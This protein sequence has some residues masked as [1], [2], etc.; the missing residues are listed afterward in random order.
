MG[1]FVRVKNSKYRVV[2]SDALPY[3]HPAFFTNRFFARF[4]KY[5]GV[6]VK[7]GQ[8]EATRNKDEEGL[9]EFLSILGGKRGDI[10]LCYQYTIS[11]PG[12]DEGRRL[13]VIHPYHQV[14]LVEFYDRY[15]KL[16]IEFCK[17]S[18]FSIRYP[19]K[20]ASYQK[21]A[22][23][24]HKFISDDVQEW[25]SNDRLRHFFV[26]R[27]Y[28]NI[29]HFYGD[30][31]FLRA[32]KQFS[33][34][35]KLDLT[36]CF[37]RIVPEDLSEA[38]FE[39]PMENATGS[40]AHCFCLLQK[41][42]H[43][44]L[45]GEVTGI[46]IGPEFSRIYAEMILQAVDVRT[47]RRLE[48]EFNLHHTRD[49][50]FYRYVDDGFL[51]Y[52]EDRVNIIF[53]CVYSE[54]L[55]RFNQQIN[56]KKVS[57]FKQ[58]PFVE[59]LAVAKEELLNLVNEMF[60]NR[61]KTF[62]G[63]M[64]S[65]QGRYDSPIHTDYKIFINRVRAIIA[66][67]K[68]SKDVVTY[69]KL[70]LFLLGLIRVRLERLLGDFNVLYR[71]YQYVDYK[72]DIDEKGLRIKDYYEASFIDFAREL[73]EILFFLLNSD[74]RMSTSLKV[75]AIINLLQMFVRG[76]YWFEEEEAFSA[77]FPI[78]KIKFLDGKISDETSNYIKN[79][80]SLSAGVMETLNVLELQKVMSMGERISPNV[81]HSYLSNIGKLKRNEESLDFFSAFELL[82]LIQG[83]AVYSDVSDLVY[84]WIDKK[85]NELEMVG[86]SSA[87]AVLTFLELLCCPWIDE[88][89][90]KRWEQKL[91]PGSEDKIDNFAR[92]QKDIFVKWRNYRLLEEMQL[93]NSSEV[94]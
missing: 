2:V 48:K 31:R 34:L 5:Y 91:F 21:K 89:F 3:E 37:D 81:L 29:N 23:G 30:Y 20:V 43:Q 40:L 44:S 7:D 4:L 38:L 92:R 64:Y 19:Y 17:R 80:E 68:T 18:H 50:R 70:T 46:V 82:H 51:F 22:N 35:K 67:S 47:E 66:A 52:N 28:G 9:K 62:K 1:R 83:N 32:E 57:V 42:F 13:T 85:M 72:L 36:E 86:R 55:K 69:D 93:I 77:K 61:L 58:R 24:F 87:E 45:P 10:R 25:E 8:L 14:Q 65:Q 6:V 60:E 54:E 49:Y 11:K 63:F 12:K 88:G 27:Y 59:P 73:T 39:V 76:R 74:S 71:Q 90:R 16:L 78:A 56:R 79:K 84:C 94:Y 15:K 53:S 41:S 75:V 33:C 26:Y